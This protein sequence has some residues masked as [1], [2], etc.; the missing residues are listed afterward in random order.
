MASKTITDWITIT[1][2]VNLD[3]IETDSLASK[4]ITDYITL[5]GAYDL[6]AAKVLTDKISVTVG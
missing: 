2:A 4:V 6:D 1:Q 3:T 5:T